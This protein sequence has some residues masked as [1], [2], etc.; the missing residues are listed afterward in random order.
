[1]SAISLT[2]TDSY[3]WDPSK[4]FVVVSNTGRAKPSSPLASDRTAGF[5]VNAAE[6]WSC[7]VTISHLFAFSYFTS[8]LLIL[9]RTVDSSN[10]KLAYNL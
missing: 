4:K 9:L 2:D 10:V 3:K 5:R 8:A 6:T 1:M 7:F